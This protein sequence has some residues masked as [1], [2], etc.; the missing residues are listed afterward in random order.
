MIKLYID[1]QLCD[2]S[3]SE[4]IGIDYAMFSIEDI[5]KRKGSRSYNFDLPK[6]T[7]NRKIF[8]VSE[9]VTNLS[10]K[11]Y[12]KLSA[13]LYSDGVD[14]QIRFAE[15]TASGE[16]YSV[17][18]YGSNAS[19]FDIIKNRKLTDLDLSSQNHY[20]TFAN[21]VTGL[22]NTYE[23]GDYY[24][25]P[26][27]DYG[28]DD[29]AM[30]NTVRVANPTYL[31]PALFVDAI[32]VKMFSEAGYT[33]VNTMNDITDYANERPIMPTTSTYVGNKYNVVFDIAADAASKINRYGNVNII[34]I[35]SIVSYDGDYWTLPYPS[36][37]TYQSNVSS[38]NGLY[39]QDNIT[40]GFRF[41]FYE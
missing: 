15:L 38:G 31:P 33:L 2:L 9:E 5:A 12:R 36:T 26:I 16:M 24:C 32:L 37:Y 19:F 6:T 18:L 34:S 3:G 25:Y 7:N 20:W 22:T 17:N 39:F 27:I 21:V 10:R 1:G 29:S 28:V 41:T 11:P 23:A 4:T 13:L 30:N 8:E 35:N 14:L 40:C